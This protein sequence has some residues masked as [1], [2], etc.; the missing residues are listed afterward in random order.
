MSRGN[1]RQPQPGRMTADTVLLWTAVLGIIA[2]TGLIQLSVWLGWRLAGRHKTPPGNPLDTT[3]RLADGTLPWPPESTW[4]LAIATTVL[5]LAAT[6]AGW[7]VTRRRAARSRVDDT[8]RWL[9]TGADIA[10]ISH[11]T[12]TQKAARLVPA[13]TGP[14]IPIGLTVASGQPVY[15]SWEDVQL[16]IWGPRTG[17]TTA[18]AIPAIL[19]APGAVLVTSNKRDVA[20]ATRGPREAVGDVWVFDPQQLAAAP[21][22]WWWNPLSYVTDEVRAAKLAGIFAAAGRPAGARV[23]A[24]FA[25]AAQ[26]LLA[27]L[28]L[29]AAVDNQPVTR[30]S[31]WLTRPDDDTAIDILKDVGYPLTADQLTGIINAPD[32]QRAG[33]YGTATQMASVLTNRA[34]ATWVTPD[35]ADPHRP[36]LD[37]D[38]FVV[39]T[40]TLYLLSKEG[41]GSAGPLTTALTVAVIEAAEHHATHSAGGR[42]PVPLLAVLDEAANVCRW[43]DLPDL[44]SHFGSRGICLMTILQSWSQGADVWGD[45]GMRKL[46]SAANVVVFGGGVK[47]RDFLDNVSALIGDYDKT[48]R[49]VSS[50]R[51]HRQTSEH[52][53]RERILDAADLAALPPGRAVVLASGAR[54][55]LIRTQPWWTGPHKQ[56]VTASLDLHQPTGTTPAAAGGR[57]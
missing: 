1:H 57:P 42:L 54:P 17:K 13:G 6:L 27:A 11:T 46:W 4:V 56:A 33:V 29:A 19:E 39:G 25:P 15:A 44:Y 55:T 34:A 16:D 26:D 47:E 41:K 50:G 48:T 8:S 53:S 52:L 30:V 51:G 37:P 9:G 24:Y 40:D 32:R 21:A 2:V 28:L 18:R 3:L 43:P 20:D 12:A 38:Q 22:D 14:G 23:D 7:Q 5:L 31:R 35:P 36:Q 49:S 45:A 10:P